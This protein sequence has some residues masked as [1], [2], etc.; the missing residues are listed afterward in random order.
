MNGLIAADGYMKQPWLY[1]SYMTIIF[2]VISLHDASVL[3]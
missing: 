1:N 2:V 3:C